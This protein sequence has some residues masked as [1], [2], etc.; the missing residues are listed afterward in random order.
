MK[1]L[2]WVLK[3]I[4]VLYF[5]QIY[6]AWCFK[7]FKLTFLLTLGSWIQRSFSTFIAG[8]WLIM[9]VSIH[10][11]VWLN[12]SEV[13]LLSIASLWIC[14]WQKLASL[15]FCR[16]Y[17]IIKEFFFFIRSL[18]WQMM[19]WNFFIKTNSRWIFITI[20]F[21]ITWSILIAHVFK[22]S[23]RTLMNLRNII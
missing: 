13:L 19:V 15:P 2:F 3:F 7:D 22:L 17:S 4:F 10:L 5:W 9:K 18:F 23:K 16:T 1:T 8:S 14:W 20:C 12:I 11:S 21:V 6:F